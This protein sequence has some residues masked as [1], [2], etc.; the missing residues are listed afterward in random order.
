MYTLYEQ[1][2]FIRVLFVL[3]GLGMKLIKLTIFLKL[4]ALV[5]YL[6][7]N[8]ETYLASCHQS[9]GPATKIQQYAVTLRFAQRL[10]YTT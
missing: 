9:G 10:Y 4:R 5:K 2:K 1:F 7:V 3:L 6:S 8:L